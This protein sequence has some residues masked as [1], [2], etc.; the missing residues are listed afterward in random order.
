M[1]SEK[2]ELKAA[3]DK[4][5]GDSSGGIKASSEF[6]NARAN[7]IQDWDAVYL[8]FDPFSEDRDVTI[9]CARHPRASSSLTR[10]PEGSTLA[11]SPTAPLTTG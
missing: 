8:E 1:G 2:T 4:A 9:E 5:R 11:S 3:I 6:L 10:G 7:Q